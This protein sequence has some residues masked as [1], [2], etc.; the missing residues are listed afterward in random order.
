MP[1]SDALFGRSFST[2]NYELATHSR[3][4]I[5][6]VP[7]STATAAVS[8]SYFTAKNLHLAFFSEVLLS[9][10]YWKSNVNNRFIS[11][12]FNLFQVELVSKQRHRQYNRIYKV[13]FHQHELN[14]HKLPRWARIIC[15]HSFINAR[16]HY[17]YR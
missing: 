13:Y 17:S 12:L 7:C 4:L 9:A 1:S 11:Q 16:L 14:N 3:L 6:T 2:M 8:R 10:I 5:F 15:N